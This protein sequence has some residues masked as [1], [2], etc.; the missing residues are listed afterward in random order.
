MNK[1]MKMLS[2]SCFIFGLVAAAVAFISS[3]CGTLLLLTVIFGSGLLE[4]VVYCAIGYF[5]SIIVLLCLYAVVCLYRF[6]ER[7]VKKCE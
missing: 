5:G 6:V 7:Q 1:I 2:W 3:M 4:L